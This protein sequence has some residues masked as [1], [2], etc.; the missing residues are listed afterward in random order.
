ML[1]DAGEESICREVDD[2]GKADIEKSCPLDEG[3]GVGNCGMVGSGACDSVENISLAQDVAAN[4]G[5]GNISVDVV[6]TYAGAERESDIVWCGADAGAENG[7]K[8]GENGGCGAERGEVDC[9]SPA[10]S[11]AEDDS[12][13]F[14]A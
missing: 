7:C 11:P 6:G 13:D 14:D 5:K 8:V 1:G 9:G 4:A 2:G 10:E 12:G 3:L